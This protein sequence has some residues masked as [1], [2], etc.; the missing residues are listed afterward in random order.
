MNEDDTNLAEKATVV[1]GGGKKRLL[2]VS[3]KDVIKTKMR[4]G[5]EALGPGKGE[6]VR[7]REPSESGESGKDIPK[8]GWPHN[9][10]NWVA[11]IV[12]IPRVERRNQFNLRT[13]SKFYE[14][15]MMFTRRQYDNNLKASSQ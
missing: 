7:A 5:R 9:N 12:T 8:G 14:Y 10:D 11:S 4:R 15:K 1:G 6:S 3:A 2:V 13:V